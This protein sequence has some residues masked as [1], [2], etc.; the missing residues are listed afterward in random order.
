M[1]FINNNSLDNNINIDNLRNNTEFINQLNEAER[2]ALIEQDIE[3]LY[4]VLDALLLLGDNNDRID[5]VYNSIL[6]TALS[7]FHDKLEQNENFD[8]S[9]NRDHLILRAIYE[10]AIEQ[11]RIG[12]LIEAEEL[13]V[14]LSII[15]D[16]PVFKGAMQIHLISILKKI[17][18]DKFIEEFVDMNKMNS[19]NE[20]F[21]ILYFKE[22]ANSFLHANSSLLIDAIKR[23]Q[24]IK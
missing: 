14:M 6:E 8:L 16:H 5:K 18:F 21:F 20:S 12:A 7:H 19:E 10:F 15:T 4:D 24:E 2:T 1:S 13:F 3:K 22:K 11:Y 23:S 9:S 17:N